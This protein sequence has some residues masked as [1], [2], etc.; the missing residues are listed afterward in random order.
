MTEQKQTG[1][2]F[3]LQDYIQLVG[4]TDRI[5]RPDKGGFISSQLPPIL[6]RLNLDQ[7]QWMENATTFE[8]NFYRKFGCKR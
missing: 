2:L 6:Q 8:K 7:Q 4:Y 1:I 3:G 5:I